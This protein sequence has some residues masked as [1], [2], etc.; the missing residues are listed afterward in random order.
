MSRRN[1][2][3]AAVLAAFLA[4]GGGYAV[5]AGGASDDGDRAD[6]SSTAAKEPTNTTPA[7]KTKAKKRKAKAR[8][9]RP[10]RAATRTG[11]VRLTT[12]GGGGP[13]VGLADNRPE[14]FRDRRFAE[15]G[16]KYV[17]VTV[18]YDDVALGGAGRAVLDAYFANARQSGLSPLVSFYRSRRGTGILPS[19]EQFRRNVRLFRKRYPWIHE[20]STWNEANFR[21]QPTSRDPART[22]AFYRI[23][24]QECS[25]GRCTVVTCDFRPD[26]TAQADRWLETFKRGIG[27]GRHIWGLAP[28]VDVN[29]RSTKLTRDFLSRTSG[30]VWADEV[31]ALN[32]FGK[33]VRPNIRRQDRVMAYLLGPYAGV[34]PRLKRIYVYHW[35]AAAGNDLFDSGLLDVAGRPRPAYYRFRA[36]IGK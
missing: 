33:G 20:F 3:L 2:I 23:L 17:R 22:A 26:G 12:Q 8:K 13:V 4:G 14:T 28:Y 30:P 32:F 29:R 15:T 18:P 25:G 9:K 5:L 7:P 36:A 35:R 21:A 34:S 10:R 27:P 24:R 31:G 19:P 6:T 16:I 11:D 1:R